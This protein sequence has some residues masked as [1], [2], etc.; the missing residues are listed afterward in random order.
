MPAGGTIGPSTVAH[1]L[2]AERRHAGGA[3]QPHRA[4]Q[5]EDLGPHPQAGL[6]LVW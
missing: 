3:A 2:G 4:G 6:A 1:V 5:V